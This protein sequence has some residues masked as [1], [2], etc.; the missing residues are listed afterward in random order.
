MFYVRMYHVVLKKI[1]YYIYIYKK[2]ESVYFKLNLIIFIHYLLAI[3]SKK[4]NT[5]V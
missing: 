4:N 2:L 5:H 3:K 1:K